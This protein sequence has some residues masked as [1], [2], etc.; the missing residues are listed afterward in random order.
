MTMFSVQQYRDPDTGKYRWAVLAANG[1][2]Y[3]PKGYGK[4]A[5]ESLAKRLNEQGV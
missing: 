3:F 1:C 4:S 5:A 2:F